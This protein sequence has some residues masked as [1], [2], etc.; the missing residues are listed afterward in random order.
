M[1]TIQLTRTRS[2]TAVR[3][4]SVLAFSVATALSARLSML[5]PFSPVPI[6]LQVLI[7]LLSGLVLGPVDGLLSQAFYLQAILLG[8]APT[9]LGLV[10]IAAFLSPTAGYLIAFPIAALCAGWLAQK[11]AW[12]RALGGISGL[13]IIYAIGTIWL[14]RFVGGLLPALQLGVLPFVFVDVAKAAMAVGTSW[15]VSRAR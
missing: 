8:I 13:C 15:L 2:T 10:G 9:S 6:T 12:A 11:G 7:V 14:S 1:T 5:L 3:L 4:L